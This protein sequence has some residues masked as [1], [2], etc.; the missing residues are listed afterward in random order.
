MSDDDVFEVAR[1]N[2]YWMLIG[3]VITVVV[4]VFAL[5]LINHQNRLTS[6]S[7]R[8]NADFLAHRFLANSDCFAYQ[9]KDTGRTYPGIID[10]NKFTTE[11]MNKCYLPDKEKGYIDYNFKLSLSNEQKS[12]ITNNFYNKDDFTLH[13]LVL[14]KT[15]TGLKKDT[16]I[17]TV[18]QKI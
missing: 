18:Q 15:T 10:L 8:L 9:D 6:V 14:V 7:P 4:F 13:Y 16:L 1:K 2:I 3:V 12:I 5:I 17:I 11:Q